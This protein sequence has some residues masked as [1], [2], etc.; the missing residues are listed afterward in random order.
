MQRAEDGGHFLW[1]I[2][3]GRTCELMMLAGVKVL[4]LRVSCC[5]SPEPSSYALS[6]CLAPS[7]DGGVAQGL[8]S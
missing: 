4:L 1:W 6:R 7:K 3:Q 8:C 2:P 5:Q